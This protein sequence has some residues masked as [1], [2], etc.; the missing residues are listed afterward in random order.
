MRT[1]AVLCTALALVWGLGWAGRASADQTRLPES[2]TLPLADPMPELVFGHTPLGAALEK[3]G[4]AGQCRILRDPKSTIDLAAPVTGYFPRNTPLRAVLDG[5]LRSAGGKEPLTWTLQNKTVV[6]CCESRAWTDFGVWQPYPNL[7]G[8]PEIV[9]F[10]KTALDVERY[11]PALKADAQNLVVKAP[12]SF[13]A[14]LSRLAHWTFCGMKE[15]DWG[16]LAYYKERLYGT[17]VS[18]EVRAAPAWQGLLEVARRAEVPLVLD[19]PRLTALGLPVEKAVTLRLAGVRAAEAV[20]RI[21]AATQPT[22]GKITAVADAISGGDVL[23]LTDPRRVE[24]HVAVFDVTPPALAKLGLSPSDARQGLDTFLE[25]LCRKFGPMAAAR[26]D[27]LDDR[28]AAV[29]PAHLVCFQSVDT[30]H[31]ILLFLGPGAALRDGGT[32]SW[33]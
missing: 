23:C 1:T 18:V 16:R 19:E 24:R 22:P 9:R 3:I 33:Y 31:E 7:R 32:Q 4:K 25:A 17:D 29:L 28:F 15:S 11:G 6:V 2:I 30:L 10:I 27:S 13:Q 26:G 12:L 14:E 5:V 8:K 21:L 20:D